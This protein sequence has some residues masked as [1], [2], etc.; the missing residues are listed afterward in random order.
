MAVAEA[1]AAWQRTANRCFV[2]E[3]AKRAPKL[4]CCQSSSSSSKQVDGG[5]TN[6]AEMPENSAVGFMPFHRNA[7]YSSL[8]PDTR[9]WLQLQPSY[10]YQ[11]GF[12]YEQLDKLENEVEILRAEFVNAPS[13]I[14]EIRPHDDR[15]S[16][17]FDGNKK[18]EPSFDPHFRISAD[19]RNR[20]PNVKNQEAGVLYDKNA[21]EFIEPKDTKENSKLMDLDPFEC[22]RPQKS[23]DYCFDS[24][25][26][27]SGSEKSVP[28]W[29]T[30]DKDDLAS[31]VAQKSVDYIANCD[32]PPPQKLHL[33][34]YPHGRP[35]A[36]DHDDSIALSLDG[37]AQSGCISS[38]LVHAHGCPS[39][40]S[41][42]G[43][44]RASVEG[45]L[46]SGLNKPFS[47]IATHKEMIEIGQVP[48]GDPCKAQLLEALRHS[49]TRAREA[50]KVAKQACAEREHIIKLFFRQAS[51]LF[52]YK[53]WFHLLQLESLY[54]Q[55]KNG[56]QPMSTLFPVA[57][58]WMPQK[59][60]KMRKSWQKST[61]GKRGKRGRPSHDISKYAVALALGLGLVG[62]GLLLGWTVG[63]MLPI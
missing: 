21:Q 39:S 14:D 46:Q 56:G 60:R 53:Q 44:H 23:D 54:Y 11:K 4:A 48:E 17:R 43:R 50:E 31:L 62:A 51:Q 24:E 33:R 1:R 55:V 57:L 58:P 12:T 37:K 18:Y 19:Y 7:S 35:G 26:P 15:G 49:Q 16:T 10:G 8:P 20:D 25:S 32:L 5:P 52:A 59:G 41:M 29:R 36:S 45:H 42:H 30:T 40:E 6:A 2:Q 47:S 9:W 3:D 28:W 61:R 22:L 63:W 27:F 38:P 34:R 13:I